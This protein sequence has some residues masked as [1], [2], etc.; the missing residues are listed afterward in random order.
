M[1]HLERDARLDQ[2]LVHTQRVVLHL[3]ARVGA[4]VEGGGLLRIDQRHPR[5]RRLVPQ[6]ALV[7]PVP[8]VDVLD[9]RQPALVVQV[10]RELGEP[11][12]QPVGDPVGDP[13]ADLRR[14]LDR[15]LPAIRLLDPH[16]EDPHDGLA[17]QRRPVLFAVLAVGPGRGEPA[18]RLAVGEQRGRQLADGLHVQVAQ[19]AAAG[20][21][22]VARRRVDFADFGIPAPPQVEQALL[23]PEDMVPPRRVLRVRGARQVHR[24]GG[25]EVGLAVLAVA[26]ARSRPA[27]GENAVDLVARHDLARHLGHELEGVGTEAAGD[28]H[29]RAGPVTAFAALRVHGD[30]VG[31]RFVDVLVRGVR[32]G[33]CHHYH[34]QLA[35][36]PVQ[37]AERVAIAHPG[38]AMVKR[39]RGGVVGDAAARAQ[40][41]G[42]GVYAPEIVE[43]EA[44]IVAAGVVLYQGE[45][46]PAHR[47]VEPAGL[48]GRLGRARKRER[49][50]K[51]TSRQI[52]RP[53]PGMPGPTP[54]DGT[55]IR[56]A[57]PR[58]GHPG[59]ARTGP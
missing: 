22:D 50:Q 57:A 7:A 48:V 35:A 3:L 6:V 26:H 12:A 52:H 31:V 53:G 37:L 30:P 42:V 1:H 13:D 19:G 38:A 27:V 20:V 43:P 5:Q 46:G 16:T 47:P 8:V 25:A 21:G 45:L 36:A 17:A 32:I 11:R 28:P 33:A 49:G 15:I 41:R 55:R 14:G 51:G 39:N 29:L 18:P 24:V 10:A 2:R 44:R 23:A 4:A 40:A 56:T 59:P 34:A 9:H 58:R 54:S